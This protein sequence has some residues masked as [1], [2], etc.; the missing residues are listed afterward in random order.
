[1]PPIKPRGNNNL[2][3]LLALFKERKYFDEAIIP[4]ILNKSDLIPYAHLTYKNALYGLIDSDLDIIEPIIDNTFLTSFKTPENKTYKLQNFAYEAFKDLKA[5]IQDSIL[6]GKYP[7]DGLFSNLS[8]TKAGTDINIYLSE[9]RR[10]FA[11]NFKQYALNNPSINSSIKTHEDFIKYFI[12]Y[13]RNESRKGKIITKSAYMLRG[14]FIS[15]GNFLIF[16]ISNDKAGDDYFNYTKYFDTDE[17][18][19][20]KIFCARHGFKIDIS[21]PWRLIV[22]LES[23]AMINDFRTAE[24]PN[25]HLGYMRRYGINDAEQLLKLRYRKVYTTEFDDMRGF[26]YDSYNIFLENNLVYAEDIRKICSNNINIKKY[27]R[28]TIEKDKFFESIKDTMLIKPYVYFRNQET[29]KGLTQ[30]KFNNITR[31]AL[32]YVRVGK[33]LDAMKYI[34]DYF[35]DFDNVLYFKNLLGDNNNKLP[36]EAVSNTG[37]PEIIF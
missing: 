17:F 35:K 27:F 2:K 6:I 22:D 24:F 18:E 9:Y 32:S 36:E 8:I 16:N 37:I 19:T 26:M 20:F 33:T 11:N 4:Y 7:T 14:N 30:Q 15:L 13:L 34:N 21:M 29:K 28:E 31:E 1:M 5:F 25:L 3:P 12:N 10:V 23:P